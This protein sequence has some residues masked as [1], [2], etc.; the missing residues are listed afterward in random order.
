MPPG[1][2]YF[3]VREC[4]GAEL[5]F[6]FL[7]RCAVPGALKGHLLHTTLKRKLNTVPPTFSIFYSGA[8]W[9]R[10]TL[11][12]QV[13]MCAF[14][15]NLSLLSLLLY[16]LRSAVSILCLF[17]FCTTKN[18]TIPQNNLLFSTTTFSPFL[19]RLSSFFSF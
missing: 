7:K 13:E 3:F 2:V 4:R 18:R 17:F 16:C 6:D 9:S 5:M 11:H 1:Y 19:V 15:H 14:H 12:R 10:A 8:G